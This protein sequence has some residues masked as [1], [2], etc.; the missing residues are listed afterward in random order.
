RERIRHGRLAPGQH[1]IQEDLANDLGVSRIPLREALHTLSAEGLIS[2]LPQR[3][4][5]VAEL[6]R[7]EVA[8]LFELRATLEP[9]LVDEAV[10]GAR[11]R[12][13]DELQV[14]ADR[15]RQVT[16]DV[17]AGQNYRF[18]R[19]IYSLAEQPLTLRFVDQLLHLGEPYSRRWVRSGTDLARIDDEHQAMVDALRDGDADLLRTTIVDHITGARDHVLATFD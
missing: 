12:D 14:C 3:G 11:R 18:H 8:E 10:R 4:M 9:R 13:I 6:S 15:M 16:G 17:R 7:T 19:H 1:L 5:A 2:V